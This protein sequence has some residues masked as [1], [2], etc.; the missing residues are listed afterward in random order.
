MIH[1]HEVPGSIP[2]LATRFVR[3]SCF[4]LLLGVSFFQREP[5]FY[6]VSEGEESLCYRA[7]VVS[8]A[9]LSENECV[10]GIQEALPREC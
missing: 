6:F 3:I 7:L 2:G 4:F 5:F 10:E 8:I 1:N 9:R